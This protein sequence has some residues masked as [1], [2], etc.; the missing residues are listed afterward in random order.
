M[1]GTGDVTFYGAFNFANGNTQSTGDAIK[2]NTLTIPE[3]QSTAGL[4]PVYGDDL[5]AVLF[6]NPVA[7]EATLRLNLK[8]NEQVEV[9]LLDIQGKQVG[10]LMLFDG[11]PGN[12]EFK[13]NVPEG[14]PSGIYRLL[15]TQ[16]SA[17]SVKT[18]Y[19]N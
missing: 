3:D 13:I 18:F 7:V 16:G 12:R 4:A 11:A 8:T 1:A 17:S 5:S 15:I 6:P 9:Q 10:E 19:K 14:L 2:T